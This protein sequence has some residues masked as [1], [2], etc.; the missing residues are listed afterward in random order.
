MLKLSNLQCFGVYFFV[1]L[2]S[3][4]PGRWLKNWSSSL[5]VSTTAQ[6]DEPTWRSGLARMWQLSVHLRLSLHVASQCASAAQLAYDGL[7][8]ICGLACIQRLQRA[9]ATQRIV[10]YASWTLHVHLASTCRLS[11]WS[12]SQNTIVLHFK[13][14]KKEIIRVSFC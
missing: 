9:C 10:T 8:R 4:R 6:R 14:R 1:E 11:A 7:V 5:S 12:I 13:E 3:R 2:H